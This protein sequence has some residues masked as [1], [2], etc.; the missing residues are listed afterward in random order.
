[1]SGRIEKFFADEGDFVEKASQLLRLEQVRFNL[2]HEQA[3]AAYKESMAQLKNLESKLERKKALFEKGVVNREALDDSTTDVELGRARADTAKSLLETAEE[4]LKDSVLYAPFP[5][6]VVEKRMNM[7]EI[8]ST[9]SNQYVFHIVDTGS[10]KVE[11][12]IFET[13]KQYLKTGEKVSVDVDA[14]PGRM[15]QG[16]ITVVNPLIDSA[17][18]KF[19]VKIEIPNPGF[20]LETGMFARIQI[21]EEKREAAL[22]IPSKAVIARGDKKVLF[23]AGEKTAAERHI[24]T[25]LI[26]SE[27]VEVLEGVEEGERVIVEGLYAVKDGTPLIIVE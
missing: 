27:I 24:K 16:E 7:G 20:L 14:I 12:D 17:S 18:R 26:T 8:F 3:K 13:K 21:P 6:F 10:V 1:V 2:A 9:V 25:G 11:V 5:G 23:I 15:F 19:L 22:L 4:D